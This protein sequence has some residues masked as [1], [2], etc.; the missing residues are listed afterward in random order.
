MPQVIDPSSYICDC[1]NQSDFSEG[2]IWEMKKMSR[3]K[4]VRLGDHA[5]HTIVFY[6]GKEIEMIC[7]NHK[8]TYTFDE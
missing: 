8:T 7:P 3:R 5:N 2:T 6:E 1:G 4:R